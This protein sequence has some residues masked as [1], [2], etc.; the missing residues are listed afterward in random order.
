[1]LSK[2]IAV[3]TFKLFELMNS[4]HSVVKIQENLSIAIYVVKHLR[5]VGSILEE[6]T[7]YD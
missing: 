6:L 1:V 7:R 4:V 2:R 3:W 5:H